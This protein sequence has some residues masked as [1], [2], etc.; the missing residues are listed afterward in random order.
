MRVLNKNI[1]DPKPSG[2]FLD[3]NHTHF[4]LVNNIYSKKGAFGQEIDFRSE[5]EDQLKSKVTEGSEIPMI[6]MVVNGGPNTLYTVKNAIEKKI[7]MLILA[8]INE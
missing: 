6:L 7:P 4:L 8:V 3:R 2:T 5:L 1:N